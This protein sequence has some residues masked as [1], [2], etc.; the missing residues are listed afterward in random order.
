MAQGKV[1][2]IIPDGEEPL[3]SRGRWCSCGPIVEPGQTPTIAHRSLTPGDNTTPVRMDD[4][5]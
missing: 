4:D 5:G 1:I 3:H 2:E